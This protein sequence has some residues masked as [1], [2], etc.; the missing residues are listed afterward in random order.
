MWAV[1]LD[2]LDI[3]GEGGLVGV[4]WAQEERG[5]WWGGSVGAGGG[6]GG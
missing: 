3:G 6:E 4:M 5:D 2:S 1:T